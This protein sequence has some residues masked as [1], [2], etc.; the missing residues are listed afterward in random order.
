MSTLQHKHLYCNLYTFLVCFYFFYELSEST[1]KAIFI[2]TSGAGTDYP[3]CGAPEFIPRFSGV[4]LGQSVVFYVVICR[5]LFVFLSFFFIVCT[6]IYSFGYIGI[7]K[8]FISNLVHT[9]HFWN[10]LHRF[11]GYAHSQRDWKS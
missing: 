8:R 7:F 10:N 1:S 2:P 3:S 9:T 4:R 11:I 5:S 6:S